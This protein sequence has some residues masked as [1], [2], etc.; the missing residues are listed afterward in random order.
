MIYFA[1]LFTDVNVQN[2]LD[3]LVN[4]LGLSSNNLTFVS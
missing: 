4:P 3:D 1:L 2:K